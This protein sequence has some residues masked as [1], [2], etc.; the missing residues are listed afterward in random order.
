MAVNKAVSEASDIA[1]V[2]IN[3]DRDVENMMAEKEKG[4]DALL[5]YVNRSGAAALDEA[6]NKRLLWKLVYPSVPR[7]GCVSAERRSMHF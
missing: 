1:P 4:A 3:E 7:Q 2:S 5:T 6:T